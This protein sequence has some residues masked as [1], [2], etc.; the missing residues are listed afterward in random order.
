MYHRTTNLMLPLPATKLLCLSLLTQHPPPRR[1]EDN[2]D[3]VTNAVVLVENTNKK[4]I[5]EYGSP[6]QF[7]DSL[8]YLL[9]AQVYDGE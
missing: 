8:S 5:E 6:E 2:F 4:P 7:L 9:G 1:Y 3:V